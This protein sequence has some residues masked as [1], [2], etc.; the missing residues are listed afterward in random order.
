VKSGEFNNPVKALKVVLI[1]I[2]AADSQVDAKISTSRPADVREIGSMRIRIQRICASA[3]LL[4]AQS[5]LSDANSCSAES[6]D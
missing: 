6:S 5:E 3:S 4:L 2:G 1:R